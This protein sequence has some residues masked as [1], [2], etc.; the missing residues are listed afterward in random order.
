V[1]VQISVCLSGAQAIGRTVR[2]LSRCSLVR[3]H[4]GSCRLPIGETAETKASCGVC[5]VVAWLW[6]HVCSRSKC[7]V[8]ACVVKRAMQLV[9]GYLHTGDR[10]KFNKIL[11]S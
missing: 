2:Q 7:S 3:T 4:A 5:S 10:K 6:A 1:R 9:E 8:T 11:L